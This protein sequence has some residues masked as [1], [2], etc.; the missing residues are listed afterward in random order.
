MYGLYDIHGHFLPGMDDG[1]KSAEE[2]VRMLE[3]SYEQGIANMIATP[4]YYPVESVESFLSRRQEAVQRLEKAIS[5]H[6]G[7]LPRFLLGAEVAYRPGL[8]YEPALEKLCLGGTRYLLL[9]LP[10]HVWGK[11]VARELRKLSSVRGIIP[12][13][14]HLERYAPLQTRDAWYQVLDND[15]LVQMNAEALLQMRTRGK[16]L[17]LLRRGTVHLLGSDCHNTQKRP[18][19]LGKAAA[20]L[21]KKHL[22][23]ILT[24]MEALCEDIFSIE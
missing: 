1:S 4:H 2:S 17:R 5:K 6:P 22:E 16:A 15:V 12:I 18:P 20:Y 14:A 7:P 8:S 9:E 13:L 24:D 3:M 23:P 21:E 19:N 11:D 10:F